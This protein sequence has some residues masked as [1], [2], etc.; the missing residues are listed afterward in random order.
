M[1]LFS[2]AGLPLL[3]RTCFAAAP[4]VSVTDAAC[5]LVISTRRAF[6][7]V[8]SHLVSWLVLARSPAAFRRQQ[9]LDLADSTAIIQR[10]QAYRTPARDAFMLSYSRFA[11]WVLY[12]FPCLFWLVRAVVA[13]M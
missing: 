10:L 4:R 12:A 8:I 1:A 11:V 3:T 13:V 6:I 9:Q 2:D 5:R 7:Y